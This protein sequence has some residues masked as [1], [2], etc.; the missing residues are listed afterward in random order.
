MSTI[1]QFKNHDDPLIVQLAELLSE[2]ETA[3]K[4]KEISKSELEEIMNDILEANEINNLAASIDRKVEYY[5]VVGI[6][7]EIISILI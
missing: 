3:Y 5:R 2:A 7:K 1:E 4:N 6:I